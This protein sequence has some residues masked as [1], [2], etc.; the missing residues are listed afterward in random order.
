MQDTKGKTKGCQALQKNLWKE[1]KPQKKKERTQKKEE[2]LIKM[3][4]KTWKILQC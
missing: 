2:F 3:T 4:N 1:E